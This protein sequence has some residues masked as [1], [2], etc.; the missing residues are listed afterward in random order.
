MCLIL[1][2]TAPASDRE[3]FETVSRQPNADGLRVEVEHLSRWP[4]ARE[5]PVRAVVSE[6]GGCACSLLSDDADWNA[7]VWAF[8][9]DVLDR[10]AATLQ[11]LAASVKRGVTV[12]ALWIGDNVKET[13]SV[14]AADLVELAR[15]NRL[16]TRTRYEVAS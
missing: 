9:D 15:K 4:W 2:V 10:L 3:K 13:R 16:G 6:A 1:T 11:H 14:S 8:R 12:E 5:R 7:E